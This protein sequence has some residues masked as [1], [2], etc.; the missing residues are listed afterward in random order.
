M[1]T[2]TGTMPWGGGEEGLDDG[3]NLGVELVMISFWLRGLREQ[4]GVTPGL[5]VGIRV[6]KAGRGL[7]F[8]RAVRKMK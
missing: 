7:R 1:R 2:L 5:D 8:Q 6:R 3:E 4:S